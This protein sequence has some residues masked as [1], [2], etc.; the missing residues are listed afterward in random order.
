VGQPAFHL[1]RGPLSLSKLWMKTRLLIIIP[2]YNGGRWIAETLDSL[3]KQTI[4]LISMTVVVADDGSTDNSVTITESYT[5]AFPD[6]RL[7]RRSKNIGQ[8]PNLNASLQS[9]VHEF[10]WVLILHSDDLANP[11]WLA[12]FVQTINDSGPDIGSICC[13]WEEFDTEI[14]VAGEHR[15]DA[16]PVRVDGN[17][18][19]VADSLMRG[20]W[21]HISG[22]AIRVRAFQEIG[23]FN[24]SYS[25]MADFEWL[26]RCLST[27]W[28]VLYLPRTLIRYRRH[29]HSVSSGALGSDR[30]LIEFHAL[31]HQMRSYLTFRQINS[32]RFRLIQYAMR[33]AFRGL[34]NGNWSRTQSSLCTVL[35]LL[36]TRNYP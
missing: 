34:I 6:F 30:D 4:P 19:S 23:P 12:D 28:S 26:L 17:A 31:L 16:S 1:I 8:W 11:N 2:N 33:R 36:Q 13:S 35:S 25:H 3:T 21:W 18:S 7:L 29:N 14:S 32:K 22:C 5:Q 10:D 15:P 24:P 27:G 20:C 9:L